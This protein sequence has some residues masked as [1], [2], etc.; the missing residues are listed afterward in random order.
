MKLKR[1]LQWIVLI[2]ILPIIGIILCYDWALGY[3]TEDSETLSSIPT[4]SVIIGGVFSGIVFLSL[5]LYLAGVKTEETGNI[6]PWYSNVII[7]SLCFL[8]CIVRLIYFIGGKIWNFI[9]DLLSNN[10]H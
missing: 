2:L 4:I 5:L 10:L 8:P 7:I 9:K 3:R 6:Y 1:T